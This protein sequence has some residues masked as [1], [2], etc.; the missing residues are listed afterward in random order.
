MASFRCSHA[1][2]VV[3]AP[4]S[5]APTIYTDFD[6][7]HYVAVETA[8]R[9]DWA[10]LRTRHDQAFENSFTRG[11]AIASEMGTRFRKRCV[12]G[13]RALREKL[14][15][16]DAALDDL[17]I[18]GIKGRLME[19]LGITPGD[20]VFRLAGLLPG[21]HLTFLQFE[22]SPPAPPGRARSP[23]HAQGS[24]RRGDCSRERV[25]PTTRRPREDR[26][27]LPVASRQM[28]R[29]HPRRA[30]GSLRGFP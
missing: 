21:G 12:I 1:R 14:M 13:F 29:R 17:V 7:H 23:H 26:A 9:E 18:E 30:G 19:R 4:R 24:G 27:G 8:V 2:H 11:P 5:R 20:G 22:P 16:W 10:T 3:N 15:I 25:P 28:A 6:R